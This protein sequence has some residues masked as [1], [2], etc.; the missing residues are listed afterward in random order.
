MSRTRAQRDRRGG[1]PPGRFAAPERDLRQ[2][3][4]A[5]GAV[6]RAAVRHRS[7]ERRVL[8]SEAEGHRAGRDRS[9]RAARGPD[10]ARLS[11][12]AGA[13]RCS[14]AIR[15]GRVRARRLL[16][17][18]QP[19]H[20]RAARRSGG[21][22]SRRQRMDA[23]DRDRERVGQSCRKLRDV[24]VGDA[25]VCGV[26]GIRV[27]PEFR[28]RDRLGFAFMVNDVS[29]ERRVEVSVARVLA[30]MEEVKREGGR[31]AFVAGPVVV[32]SGGVSVF[33]R[34]H[35]PR[36]RRRAAGGK[37]ARGARRR[38]RAVRHVAR[39]RSRMRA[40]RW[41]RA[42]A[43]TCAPSTQ[44]TAP[45]VCGRRSIRGFLR[46]GIHVRGDSARRGLR[47]RGEHPRRRSIAGHHHEP[48]SRRRTATRLALR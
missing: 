18:D 26:G 38:A 43:T 40:R 44:S 20:V 23:V 39:H 10:A 32:H 17:D 7:H 47:P 24:A 36:F 8:P 15:A 1:R 28:E 27:S 31:I 46:S 33:L 37:R 3:D 35:P 45:A 14:Q 42:T 25:V 48:R 19:P 41:R 5:A 16:L 30:M 13:G 4:R 6:R 29:T 12:D 21:W 9:G 2:G 22:R 34:P 11:S